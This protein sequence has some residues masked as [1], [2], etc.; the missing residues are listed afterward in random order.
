MASF[1]GNSLGAGNKVAFQ[2]DKIY[3]TRYAMD[4]ACASDGVF[5][6][7]YVLVEYEE[8]P[9]RGYYNTTDHQFYTTPGF[10]ASSKI[11]GREGVIYQN[12]GSSGIR[13][14]YVYSAA[15]QSYTEVTSADATVY[16]LSY[17]TDMER[18]GRGYDSTIWVK[19]Y[20]TSGSNPTYRYIM[21]AELNTLTPNFHL[22]VDPPTYAPTAPYFDSSTTDLDYYLHVQG[23]YADYV[24]ELEPGDASDENVVQGKVNW[25]T[26]ESGQTYSIVQPRS[27]RAD[28]Y[29]NK[30]GFD[31]TRHVKSSGVDNSIGFDYGSSNRYYYNTVDRTGIWSGG[32]T[33]DDL[34]LWHIR[35]PALGDAVCDLYDFIYGYDAST[36]L[37]SAQ[38]STSRGDMNASYSVT[39]ALGTLNLLRDLLG[40]IREK[41]T[42]QVVGSTVT[43]TEAD[44]HT[45]YYDVGDGEN[46]SAD[47]PQVFYY[48]KY[49]PAYKIGILHKPENGDPYLTYNLGADELNNGGTSV[50]RTVTEEDIFFLDTDGIYK[51]P[52]L[53]L[54]EDGDS[55]HLYAAISR[56][57]F[58]QMQVNTEDTLSGILVRLVQELGG[59]NEVRDSSMRGLLNQAK[60][61]VAGAGAEYEQRIAALEQNY[62][63]LASNEALIQ[64]VCDRISE[65]YIAD[66]CDQRILAYHAND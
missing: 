24:H 6:G 30:A 34:R 2:F 63:N 3:Q 49:D 31:K 26:L 13:I 42:T 14:F 58:T 45:L 59:D 57:T 15:T 36:G 20:D 60:D 65:Q 5:L 43:Y 66:I 46:T 10:V 54:Y 56:W 39:S 28:I 23:Q 12:L 62:A 4:V 8:D 21:V 18:Y 64:A 16:T 41:R 52:N 33:A 11:D 17:Q 29:Y 22:T 47:A 25:A 1:Y 40:Y 44:T 53:A 32:T 51:K 35:L 38:L 27:V 37:R 55:T 7:R 48:Y 9:I 50:T 19:I 61:L